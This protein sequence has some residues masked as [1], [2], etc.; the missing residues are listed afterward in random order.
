M[1]GSEMHSAVCHSD[2]G[3]VEGRD[4]GLKMFRHTLKQRKFKL[5]APGL[6]LSHLKIQKDLEHQVALYVNNLNPSQ[7]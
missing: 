3:P 7:L 4:S 6:L 5:Q 1:E 2:C